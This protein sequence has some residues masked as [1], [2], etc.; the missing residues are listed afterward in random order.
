MV[1]KNSR[2]PILLTAVPSLKPSAWILLIA[3]WLVPAAPE[4]GAVRLA[5]GAVG[6]FTSCA[7]CDSQ[8]L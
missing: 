1:L 6:A 4:V 2:E 5:T 8:V 7:R 3:L